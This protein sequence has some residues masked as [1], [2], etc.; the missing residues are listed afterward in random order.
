MQTLADCGAP[1]RL[2]L[3]RSLPP[4]HAEPTVGLR[5]GDPAALHRHLLVGGRRVRGRGSAA[6]RRGHPVPAAPGRA[7][8]QAD[9]RAHGVRDRLDAR[10]RGDSRVRRRAHGAHDF[11]DL[12]RGA[13]ARAQGRGDRPPVVVGVPLSRPRASHGGRDARAG[14]QAGAGLHHLRRRDPLVLGAGP[15]RQ[16]RRHPRT[17]EPHRVPRRL[18]GRLPGPVR[19]VLRGVARQ[20]A[21][22][23]PGRHRLRVPGVGRRRAGR[24]RA[25]GEGEPGGARQ[26][27]VLSQCVHR[28][29]HHPGRVAGRHRPEPDPRGEADHDRERHL[30]Q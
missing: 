18:R 12:G 23:R 14:G 5:R 6:R 11:R 24:A 20:H 2:R 25:P 26:G 27:S 13:A 15:G 10:A 7:A 19:R 22:A 1:R 29:P 8:A 9:A 3:R 17:R 4:K 21:A 16:A 28:L 30:P